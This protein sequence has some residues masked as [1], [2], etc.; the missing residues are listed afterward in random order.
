M[1]GAG[2]WA[3][4]VCRRAERRALQAFPR[5]S[6]R[7]IRGQASRKLPLINDELCDTPHGLPWKRERATLRLVRRPDQRV[8][9]S[10]PSIGSRCGSG[11]RHRPSSLTVAAMRRS[12]L[13]PWYNF[14]G[15]TSW[16]D[17]RR[18]G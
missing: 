1:G 17:K 18:R 10:E 4:Q 3:G 8:S 16:F 6:N 14:T 12:V 9:S 11:P 7:L 15:Q 13:V 2:V 5:P